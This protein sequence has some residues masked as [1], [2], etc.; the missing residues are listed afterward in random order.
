MSLPGTVR[1]VA[2]LLG[3]AALESPDKLALV[4][5]GGRSLTWA[6]LEDEVA[7]LATGLGAAGILAGHRVAIA[8]TNSLEFVATYLAVLRAHAVAVPVNPRATATEVYRFALSLTRVRSVSAT[9]RMN[10]DGALE[11]HFTWS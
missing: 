9:H 10:S 7:R 4:E 8:T 2:D 5:A 6:Q 11:V 3:V 1:G